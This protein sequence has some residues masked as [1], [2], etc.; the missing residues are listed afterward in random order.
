MGLM[1]GQ[2]KIKQKILRY[3]LSKLKMHVWNLHISSHGEQ[4]KHDSIT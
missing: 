3:N 1:P 4:L 2:D